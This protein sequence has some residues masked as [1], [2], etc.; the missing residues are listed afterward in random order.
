MG[1]SRFKIVEMMCVLQVTRT[2]AREMAECIITLD[3]KP[4]LES[5]EVISVHAACMGHDFNN[6]FIYF[7]LP[8]ING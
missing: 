7:P 3:V 8:E 4:L 2:K 5:P 1:E 6:I